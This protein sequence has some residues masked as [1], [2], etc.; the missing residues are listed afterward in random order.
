MIDEKWGEGAVVNRAGRVGV[1]WRDTLKVVPYAAALDVVYND[2][3]ENV[4]VPVGL[5]VWPLKMLAVRLGKRFN[6]DTDLINFGLGLSL[7]VIRA[8]VSFVITRFV[9]DAG[10]KWQVGLA[11]MLAGGRGSAD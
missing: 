7:A 11:Y 8:D 1:A 3:L 6:H 5:E 2:A 10:L 9:D 4:T